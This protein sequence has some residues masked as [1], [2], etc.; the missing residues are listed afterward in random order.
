MDK[1]TFSTD[2]YFK[3]G[4]IGYVDA[5]GNF[6]VTDRLKELIKY[7]EYIYG[8]EFHSTTVLTCYFFCSCTEGFQ[9]P[10]A[11]LEG[12]LLGHTDISDA[13]V[14]PIY[15]QERATEVPR[16]YV[17]LTP[18][19][20]RTEEKA[21]EIVDWIASKVAPHKQL[22]G[23]VRFIEE[24]PKNASGKLLRRVLKDQAKLEDRATGPKL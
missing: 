3:T 12:V 19:N 4:D 6:Y 24:I 20:E 9:V 21:K 22:R 23:G 14:I 18:G 10:P 11:E 8:L 15:D 17:V 1:D 5:K 7:S 2:G 13:C 16:A